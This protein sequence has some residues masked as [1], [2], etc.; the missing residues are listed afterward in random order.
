MLQEMDLKELFPLEKT[1]KQKQT[2]D[3]ESNLN[4]AA[5]EIWAKIKG[6]STKWEKIFSFNTSY[7]KLYQ[8]YTRIL[9]SQYKIKSINLSKMGRE[10]E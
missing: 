9:K 4:V 3:T 8:R 1:I 7:G 10:N 6:H 5:K 2:N